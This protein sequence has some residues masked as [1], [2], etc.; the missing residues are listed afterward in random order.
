MAAVP[1][2]PRVSCCPE[3]VRP[4]ML[5]ASVTSPVFVAERFVADIAP[6]NTAPASFAYVDEAVE[7]ET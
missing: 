7:V 6:V 1:A 3:I 2:R 5:F 4:L